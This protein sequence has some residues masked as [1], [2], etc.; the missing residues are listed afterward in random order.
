VFRLPPFSILP[1]LEAAMVPPTSARYQEARALQA[2]RFAH[3]STPGASAYLQAADFAPDSTI[4]IVIARQET[5]V[6]EGAVR[7]ELPAASI[8]GAIVRF[9]PASASARAQAQG[10]FAEVGGLAL[11]YALEWWEK[12]DVLD[13][14]A[15]ALVRV[16]LHQHIPWLWVLP[17][18][19]FMAVLL[20]DLPGLLPAYRFSLCTDVLSWNEGSPRLAEMRDL[21]V[22]GWPVAP[23]TYPA[24]YQI[25]PETLAEDLQQRLALREKRRQAALL[26]HLMKEAIRRAEYQM[27]ARLAAHVAERQGSRMTRQDGSPPPAAAAPSKQG[28]LP[29]AAPAA[30]KSDVLRQIVEV[31]GTEILR[32][33]ALSLDLLELRPGARVLDVGCGVG[34]DLPALAER[35]GRQGCVVGLDHDADVLGTARKALNGQQ[36]LLVRSPAEAMP[37]RDGSFD[38]VRADRVL[39]H[40]KQPGRVLAEMLRVL[41]PGGVMTLVEPDWKSIA[42]VPGGR[43]WGDEDDVLQRL[44]TWYQQQLP[45]ALIGRQL[46]GLLRQQAPGVLAHFRVVGVALTSTSWLEVDTALRFSQSA[47]ALARAQPA[48]KPAIDAWLQ[49]VRAADQDGT[50][51]A[52]APLFFAVARKAAA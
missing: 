45:H 36:V 2:R 4:P 1:S 37:F 48:Q 41:R 47:A 10:A 23:E 17:R 8:I 9:R 30:A 50:F 14:L 6:I 16:C 35:V 32:Y 33:K 28:Y 21:R 13:T 25:S 22:K 40:V 11:G 18:H 31:G 38:R 44:L 39:Q 52:N 42:L 7:L 19:P 24:L 26:P 27:R 43:T 51:L 34:V 46:H 5:G 12:L 29:Y 15:A 20:A 49:A 3:A